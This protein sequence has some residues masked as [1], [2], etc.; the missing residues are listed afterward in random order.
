M[1]KLALI[2]LLAILGGCASKAERM[3]ARYGDDCRELGF[4]PGTEGY[5]NC[6]INMQNN[7]LG[8]FNAILNTSNSLKK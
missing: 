3:E 4:T 1:Y 8:K 7:A 2:F 6:L 5:A